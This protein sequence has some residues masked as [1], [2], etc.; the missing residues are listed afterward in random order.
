MAVKAALEKAGALAGAAN[1]PA[2]RR[3]RHPGEFLVVLLR[4]VEQPRPG[5]NQAQ[6]VM[7]EA[8]PA[9]SAPAIED[10]EFSLGQ[11]IVQAQVE[12]TVGMGSTR[13]PK[14]AA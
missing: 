9:G 8:A 13:E 10:S 3:H 6:N 11:I 5:M 7:Q 2:G 4:L 14:R 1:V 12:V